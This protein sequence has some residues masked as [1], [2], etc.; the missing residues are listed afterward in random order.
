VHFSE[1]QRV[2]IDGLKRSTN[3][4][5][6]AGLRRTEGDR[7]FV[8]E[9]DFQARI[10][11]ATPAMPPA[12]V[13]VLLALQAVEDA[14]DSRRRSVKQGRSILDLLDEL[15]TDLLAGEI[16]PEKLDALVALLGD[17]RKCSHP[18]LDAVLAEID[19]R[20]RVE[21]AKLGRF[22]P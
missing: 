14:F 4:Q 6:S 7:F 2:R 1:K 17:L 21:L 8:P 3:A 12:N 19:Q 11:S 20:A 5:S 10:A 15:K 18:G 9:F 22:P 16:V 13:A